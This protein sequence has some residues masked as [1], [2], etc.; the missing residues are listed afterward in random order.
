MSS[1][2]LTL[3]TSLSYKERE[4]LRKNGIFKP[5]PVKKAAPFPSPNRGGLGRGGER[6]GSGVKS[7]YIELTLIKSDSESF[8]FTIEVAVL[9][10]LLKYS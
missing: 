10:A 7:G 9:E 1:T 2:N 8:V 5:L 4:E 3:P 6:N